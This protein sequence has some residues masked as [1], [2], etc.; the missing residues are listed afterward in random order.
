MNIIQTYFD[1]G[2]IDVESIIFQRGR[3]LNDTFI[4]LDEMQNS[5]ISQIKCL[6]TRIGERSK[7]VVLGDTSYNQIDNNEVNVVNNGLRKLSTIMVG[8]DLCAQ[9]SLTDEE[10]VR[11]KI[12][13][14]VL[15]RF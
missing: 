2:L 9:L 3:S 12:T 6:A 11:S 10:C 4:I 8:S 13:K 7:I 14:D 1:D 5:T 15:K